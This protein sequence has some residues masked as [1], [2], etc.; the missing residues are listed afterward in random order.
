LLSSSSLN[1]N[2]ISCLAESTESD[3]WIKFLPTSIQKSPLIVPG[4][5]YN[6][7]VAPSNFLPAATASFPYQT[8]AT[9]GPDNIYFKS[10][11]K[12]PFPT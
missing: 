6:G 2:P 1:H 8:I 4:A 12:N 5:L 10:P 9:T 3:P 11:A 7:F